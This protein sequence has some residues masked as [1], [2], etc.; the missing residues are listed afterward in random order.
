MCIFISQLGNKPTST[1]K[2]IRD[3]LLKC[4]RNSLFLQK[5]WDDQHKI[6]IYESGRNT[7]YG[8][9]EAVKIIFRQRGPD[10]HPMCDSHPLKVRKSASFL[11]D[12]SAYKNWQDIKCDMNGVYDRVLRNATWTVSIHDTSDDVECD[13]LHKRK[14]ELTS[15]EQYHLIQHF[16]ANK[17]SRDLIRSIFL[18]RNS[19]GEIMH[20]CVLVQ[21]Y[22]ESGTNVQI[23]VGSHGNAKKLKR[24]FYPSV[25][26]IL[27]IS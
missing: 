3:M 15:P 22:V 23:V 27:D 14:E 26:S 11:V 19:H 7:R 20:N 6:P 4:F 5:F 17:S 16:K 12:V 21:Y 10:A 18:I 2:G 9:T 8:L 13:I 24:P 25:K 1:L